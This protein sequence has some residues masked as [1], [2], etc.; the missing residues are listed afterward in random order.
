[1]KAAISV[2]S[3]SLLGRFKRRR[4]F[5]YRRRAACFVEMMV[6]AYPSRF[7]PAMKGA[8]WDSIAA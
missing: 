2:S 7:S 3:G 5:K 1:M 6:Y 4:D 8:T